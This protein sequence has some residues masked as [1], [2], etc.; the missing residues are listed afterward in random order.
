MN[1]FMLCLLVDDGAVSYTARTNP[2]KCSYDPSYPATSNYVTAVGATQGPETNTVELV[3]SSDTGGVITSGGGFSTLYTKMDYQSSAISG[4]FNSVTGSKV[5]ASGYATNGRG[6]PDVSLAGVNYNVIIGGTNTE[7]SGTSASSPSFAAF[8]ALVNAARL[9][10]GKSTLGWLNP[11]I[12]Q[13]GS[14]FGN[15]V[16]TGNNK[17][18]AGIVCCSQGFYAAPGM[19]LTNI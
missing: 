14:Q 5:P 19:L 7:V 13:Y 6:I 8:V 10:Q 17:C 2:F 1:L 15:D 12:Y 9:S 16:V 3:C 4:Y 11:A 18:T